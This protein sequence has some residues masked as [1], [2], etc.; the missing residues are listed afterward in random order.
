MARATSSAGAR[1]RHRR[2]THRSGRRR[3]RRSLGA[4]PLAGYQFD[5]ES[6][7]QLI[8][9]GASALAYIGYRRRKQTLAE[10]G[11][12]LPEWREWCFIGGLV[13]LLASL[14]PP[15]DSWA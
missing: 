5:L 9:L 8:A 4:V 3:S 1:R 6:V 14:S 11:R 12:P 10:H 13:V 7:L 2:R 15:V